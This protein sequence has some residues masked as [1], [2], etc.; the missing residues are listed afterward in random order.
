MT[1]PGNLE[2]KAA[3]SRDADDAPDPEEDDLDDLDEVL[4]EFKA[5][6]LDV[7]A[8]QKAEASRPSIPPKPAPIKEKPSDEEPDI[9]EEFAKQLQAGMAELLG[10]MDKDPEMKK[11]FEELIK[12]LDTSAEAAAETSTSQQTEKAPQSK[13]QKAGEDSFQETIRKTMERMQESGDQASAAA[14]SSS[15]EDIL[16]QML[17]DMEKGGLGG[18]GS[19]ED[20]SKMLLGMMEQLTNKDILYEPMKELNDKFPAWLQKNRE[21]TGKDDL[22]RYE[23]QQ[24]LVSEIVGRFEASG[25]SDENAADRE[26]IVERMQKMQAAGQPP[27]DLVG[28][29]SATQEA[30]GDMDAQCPQQ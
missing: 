3:S 16:S 20:F 12:G 8:A 21:K 9:D 14:A 11:Q 2:T 7:D 26:F 23:E 22:A 5:T 10:D 30:L 15:Q 28:D 13:G 4:D 29:M 25:Y 1:E 17:K 6:R 19:D 27:P 24:R 18:D